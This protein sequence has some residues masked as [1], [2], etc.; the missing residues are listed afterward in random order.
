LLAET[1][2]LWRYMDLSEGLRVCFG[3]VPAVFLGAFQFR[4]K[5]LFGMGLLCGVVLAGVAWFGFI[6][7]ILISFGE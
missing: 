3:S 7:S 1:K 2:F 4:E 6:M 5:R